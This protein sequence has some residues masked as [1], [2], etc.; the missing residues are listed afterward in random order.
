[1]NFDFHIHSV[2]SDGSSTLK[3]IFEIGKKLNLSAIAITDH[4]TVLGLGEVD[5]LSKSYGIPFIPGV[6]FTAVEDETKFHVLG[7][8]IDYKSS[9]LISYSEQLLKEL[10]EKSKIQI[11]LMQ[12]NGI[13]IE[14]DEFFKEGQGGPLYRAKMLKT[15]SKHGY[16]R[17]DEIM[18]SLRSYFGKDA[19]YYIEDT[20]KFYNFSEVCKL[21]RDNNGIVVLAHPGKLKKKNPSVYYEVINSGLLDGV[22][23]YHPANNLEMQRELLNIAG[24]KGLI[25]TGGSD[26]HGEYN[27]LKT[28][29]CGISIPAQV[30]SNLYPYLANKIV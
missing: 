29:I 12:N 24:E 4:D 5:K 30:Y 2:Y 15:L 20:F 14:E 25:V 8:N 7:Y 11:R 9:E 21:I 22:E 27:K 16:L 13:N 6:E 1:M 26:Y 3:E 10:N 23:V 28:P 19:P 18:S 17:E